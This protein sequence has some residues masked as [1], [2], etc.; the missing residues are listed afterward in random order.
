VNLLAAIDTSPLTNSAGPVN[1]RM[2]YV[3]TWV[4]YGSLLLGIIVAALLV[5]SFFRFRRKADDEEPEQVHGNTRLEIAW[6]AIPFAILFMLFIVTA[7][8]MP[9]INNQSDAANAIEVQVQAQQFSWQI[10]YAKPDPSKCVAPASSGLATTSNVLVVP[11]GTPVN[12]DLCS[13]D[14]NHSL[15]LPNLGGQINALPG[16]TNRMWTQADHEGVWYG[17]CTELCGAGHH[18]MEI[19]V[20]AVSQGNYHRCLSSNSAMSWDPTTGKFSLSALR[21]SS[22]NPVADKKTDAGY[23]TPKDSGI[24]WSVK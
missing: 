20:I 12:L 13:T 2:L 3:Y 23:C 19:V 5:I 9:Y 4:Y 15:Y 21:D 18:A 24:T 14:V 8:N 6:T 1:D 17:Q 22:G 16:Q 11:V 7:V 10:T